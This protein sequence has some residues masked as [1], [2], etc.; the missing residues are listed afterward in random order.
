MP[1]DLYSFLAKPAD[2]DD[3]NRDSGPGRDKREPHTALTA[4]VE[5]I[6]ND[7]ASYLLGNIGL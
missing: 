5:T 2:T 6:D 7:R 4:S 3:D 1:H